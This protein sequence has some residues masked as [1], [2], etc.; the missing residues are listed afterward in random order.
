MKEY[1]KGGDPTVPSCSSAQEK[2]S[3]SAQR[4]APQ[5]APGCHPALA[6][7]VSAGQEGQAVAG[8]C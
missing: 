3:V 5:K 8:T 2:S 4:Q 7:K 6:S 1:I